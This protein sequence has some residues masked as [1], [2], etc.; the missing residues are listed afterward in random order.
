MAWSTWGG[1]ESHAL[2]GLQ[3]NT[4]HSFQRALTD[5]SELKVSS[6]LERLVFCGSTR[7]GE[8]R[9]STLLVT[10]R[11]VNLASL[12]LNWCTSLPAHPYTLTLSSL[13][14]TSCPILQIFLILLHSLFPKSYKV[15]TVVIIGKEEGTSFPPV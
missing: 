3:V 14:F 10:F 13:L 15:E 11:L 12:P 2:A 9:M 6:N 8:K 5:M 7:L 4:G 1:S